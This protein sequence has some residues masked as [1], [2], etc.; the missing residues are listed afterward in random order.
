MLSDY[1]LGVGSGDSTS[2]VGIGK[3]KEKQIPINQQIQLA[4]PTPLPMIATPSPVTNNAPIIKKFKPKFSPLEL[5]KSPLRHASVFITQA[6]TP[7]FIYFQI[8]DEDKPLYRE[9]LKELEEEF[10]SA[11]TQSSTYCPSP[12]T[13]NL[14]MFKYCILL[15]LLFYYR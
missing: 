9:M 2:T 11:S 15:H 12:V 10:R 14:L 5:R 13:G 3:V 7:K 6:I 1:R 8:E 4:A